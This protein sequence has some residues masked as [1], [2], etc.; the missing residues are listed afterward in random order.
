MPAMPARAVEL[1]VRRA[2]AALGPAS[3]LRAIAD[4]MV[5]PLFECLG[6]VIEQRIDDQDTFALRVAAGRDERYG[7]TVLVVAYKQP[8]SPAWRD[9][10]RLGASA[11]TRWTFCSNGVSLR[12]VDARRTWSRD[13]LDLISL[14]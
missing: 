14:A 8:L 1:I 6:F 11:G 5:I 10:V 3:S 13:Y 12:V 4:S 9:S 2:A 7:G